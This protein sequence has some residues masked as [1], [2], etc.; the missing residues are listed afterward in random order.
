MTENTQSNF[1]R[2]STNVGVTPHDS[3]QPAA[4]YAVCRCACWSSEMSMGSVVL[5]RKR[6][7]YADDV[8]GAPS[9]GHSPRYGTPRHH[10]SAKY[11][12]RTSPVFVTQ[13]K[14]THARFHVH[15]QVLLNRTMEP[16]SWSLGQVVTVTPVS[17]THIPKLFKHDTT[18][19]AVV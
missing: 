12:A 7:K 18:T 8:R 1:C 11:N 16:R 2:D 9:A 3:R 19:L 14:T 13:I 17:L 5:R 10:L 15:A 6:W 4:E